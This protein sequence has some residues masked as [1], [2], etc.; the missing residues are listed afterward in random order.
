MATPIE[1]TKDIAIEIKNLCSAAAGLDDIPG[2]VR[3]V[4]FKYF[5]EHWGAGIDPKQFPKRFTLVKGNPSPDGPGMALV[6][7][8]HAKMVEMILRS[9]L[10]LRY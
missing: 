5:K 6:N 4:Y 9:E 1:I 2:C 3:E 8:L 10:D 7:S